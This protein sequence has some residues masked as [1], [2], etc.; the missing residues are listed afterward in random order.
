SKRG[1]LLYEKPQD[2]E[3]RKLAATT[4]IAL[5]LRVLHTPPRATLH[6]LSSNP[7]GSLGSSLA[8]QGRS[9]SGPVGRN[10]DPA[11]LGPILQHAQ[12]EVERVKGNGKLA[13]EG[14]R[15]QWLVERRLAEPSHLHQEHL[16]RL[17]AASRHQDVER[18]GGLVEAAEGHTANATVD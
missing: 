3:Y 7:T 6:R 17:A 10:D 12:P 8:P 1:R 14:G 5:R 18:P 11:E 15:Q 4:W 16:R 13:D 2:A 9:L